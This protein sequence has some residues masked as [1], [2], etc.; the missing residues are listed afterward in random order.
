MQHAP[1]KTVKT[2]YTISE[3]A[4]E[5]GL[6]HHTVAKLIGRPGNDGRPT[7]Y[8][9]F[10][11]AKKSDASPTSQWEVPALDVGAFKVRQVLGA[12]PIDYARHVFNL[13]TVVE[14]TRDENGYINPFPKD[15]TPEQIGFCIAV[16]DEPY[17]T[18][19]EAAKKLQCSNTTLR[20][21]LAFDVEARRPSADSYLPNAY[22]SIAASPTAQIRIPVRDVDALLLKIMKGEVKS[23]SRRKRVVAE[24]V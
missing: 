5:I 8:S 17:L 15:T 24:A 20:Q 14:L 22:R 10:P 12:W 18:W 6:H 2:K 3:L 13:D 4:E 19:S 21:Y 16:Y 9:E 11:N 7:L 1:P 23:L